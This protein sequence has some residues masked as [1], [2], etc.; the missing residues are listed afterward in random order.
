[1]FNKERLASKEVKKDEELDKVASSFHDDWRELRKKRKDG[2][3]EPRNKAL[4]E[5]DGKEEWV[6][7]EDI[8]D[9]KLIMKQDIANTDFK[10][11]HEF[12]QKENLDAAET[13]VG[14]VRSHK[15]EFDEDFIEEASSKVHEKWLERNEWVYDESYGNPNL[16]LPYKELKEKEKDKDRAQVKRAIEIVER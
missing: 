5:K 10:D 4:I 6:N 16:A 12:W 13:V 3:Y 1:M 9:N 11:L 14:L 7:K 8:G 2:S 15:G